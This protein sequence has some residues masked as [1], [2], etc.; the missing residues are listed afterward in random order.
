MS[1]SFA[2]PVRDDFEALTNID[3]KGS[4]DVRY[5]DPLTA[6]VESLQAFD[7]RRRGLKEEGPPTR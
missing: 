4:G 6:L 3:H 5:I 7:V 2:Y 1:C